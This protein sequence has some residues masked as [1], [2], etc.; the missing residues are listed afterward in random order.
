M[1]T[2]ATDIRSILNNHAVFLER[3]QPATVA[4]IAKAVAYHLPIPSSPVENLRRYFLEQHNVGVMEFVADVN[5]AI[6]VDTDKVIDLVFRIWKTR[7]E[8]V[9]LPQAV[10]FSD[11]VSMLRVNSIPSKDYVNL[12]DNE[13]AAIDKISAAV[14]PAFEK[15]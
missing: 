9:Y 5:E 6:V 3:T 7:Y 13:K 15:V 2:L 14:T 1:R 11:L 4:G 10:H 12:A 8:V